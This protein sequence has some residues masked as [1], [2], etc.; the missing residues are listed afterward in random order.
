MR[1]PGDIV[2]S[3]GVGAFA[4]FMFKAFMDSRASALVCRLLC[5]VGQD[6]S[7]SCS[8]PHLD[9]EVRPRRH[10]VEILAGAVAERVPDQPPAVDVRILEAVMVAEDPDAAGGKAR[11]HDLFGRREMPPLEDPNAP[12]ILEKVLNFEALALSQR[13]KFASATRSVI[14]L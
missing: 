14:P 2:F 1:V 3:V 10:A 11:P 7:V 4:W 8:R 6:R 13:P 9:H 12:T 5:R